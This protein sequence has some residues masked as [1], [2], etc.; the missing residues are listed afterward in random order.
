MASVGTS[1]GVAPPAWLRELVPQEQIED[2][3][4]TV[5]AEL[6]YVFDAFKLSREVQAKIILLG[7]TTSPCSLRWI[8]ETA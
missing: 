2:L 7:Y 1:A 5:D 4:R 6:R 3:L 8:W